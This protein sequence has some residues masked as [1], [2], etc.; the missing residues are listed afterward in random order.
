HEDI[1]SYTN[2]RYQGGIRTD[3]G[4]LA[5]LGTELVVAVIIASDGLG[6]EICAGSALGV[7]YIG[8]VIDLGA[9]ADLGFLHLAE[10]AALA[11]ARQIRSRAKPGKRSYLGAIPERC[12]L[13]MRKGPDPDAVSDLH[14][15]PEPHIRLDAAIPPEIG[16]E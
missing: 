16:I 5:D 6:P 14:A 2:L 7:A 11:L 15:R 10:I 13:D 3:E 8:K 9:L 12:A 1:C 4:S